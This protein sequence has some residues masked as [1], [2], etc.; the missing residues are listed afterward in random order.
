MLSS[1]IPRQT[2]GGDGLPKAD[3]SQ[4]FEVGEF[5]MFCI[6]LAGWA[7]GS[8]WIGFNK[9]KQYRSNKKVLP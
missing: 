1:G 8:L 2:T 3:G 4:R 5:V 9:N 7:S 6:P